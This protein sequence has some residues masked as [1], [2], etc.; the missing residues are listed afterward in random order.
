LEN[1]RFNICP[2]AY[3]A[4]V[5]DIDPRSIVPVRWGLLPPWSSSK[6]EAATINARAETVVTAP[7]F[8][9]RRKSGAA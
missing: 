4:A 3:V 1:P 9:P 8:A 5:L 2:D 6:R 7:S